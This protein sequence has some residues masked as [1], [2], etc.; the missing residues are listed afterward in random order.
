MRRI[1]VALAAMAMS[2]AL[3]FAQQ[4]PA[5]PYKVVRTAKVGGSGGFAAPVPIIT[6]PVHLSY[7]YI[8]R[9]GGRIYCGSH[10]AEFEKK[11]RRP[12][13]NDGRRARDD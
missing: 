12:P 6:E 4:P 13:A 8:V 9:H 2:T 10:V 5:G 3:A 1:T 7:P 11:P